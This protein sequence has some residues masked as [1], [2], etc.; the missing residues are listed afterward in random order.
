M[1]TQQ[2]TSFAPKHSYWFNTP[3]ARRAIEKLD[4]LLLVIEALDIKAQQELPMISKRLDLY[5]IFPN[6]VEIW[7]SRCHNP[8]RKSCRNSPIPNNTFDALLLLLSSMSE[9]FYPQIR[10]LLSSKIPESISKEKWSSFCSRL[11][12]LIS[13]RMNI[14]RGAVRK[15]LH[16]SLEIDSGIF[17]ERSSLI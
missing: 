9:Q 10:E 8:M 12:E 7:K 15:Y 17:E 1:Q 14:R 11:D 16:F 13:E 5:K 6:Y 4:L 2:L 3:Q